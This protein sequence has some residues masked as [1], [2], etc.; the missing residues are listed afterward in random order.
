VNT[1]YWETFGYTAVEMQLAGLNIVS[2][3]SPGI[4]DTVHKN[5]GILYEKEDELTNAIVTMLLK[6]NNNYQNSLTYINQHFSEH[7]VINEWLNLF[8]EVY[9]NKDSKICTIETDMKFIKW[10]LLNRKFKKYIPFLP[11]LNLYHEIFLKF[12][13]YIFRCKSPKHVFYKI[14]NVLKIS[15]VR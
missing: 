8:N 11:S 13:K 10:Q 2:Y 14:V 9:Y 6:E 5:S 1:H 15:S 12:K 3:K 4:I 7:M